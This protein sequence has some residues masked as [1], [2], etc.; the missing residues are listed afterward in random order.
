MN[1]DDR[2]PTDTLV[3]S[4]SHLTHLQ[5]VYTFNGMITWDEAKRQTNI[6]KHGIDFVGTE[7]IL[8]HPM[9][10]REDDGA[11]YGEQRLQ[12]LALLE[13]RVVFVVWTERETGA[14]IISIRKADRHEQKI[15]FRVTG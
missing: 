7:T 6:A 8:D 13:G 11:S 12:S 15:Y 3:Y 9:V 4:G 14:H 1:I 2:Q 5:S 10:T